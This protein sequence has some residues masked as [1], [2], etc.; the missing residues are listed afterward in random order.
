MLIAKQT[1]QKFSL[2]LACSLLFSIF[3][4]CKQDEDLSTAK[5]LPALHASDA[6]VSSLY[7]KEQ[8]KEL[9]VS[10]DELA[11]GRVHMQEFAN[12]IERYLAKKK[13]APEHVA[14]E[15][16]N[17]KRNEH[18]AL[19]ENK[20][21]VAASTYKFPLAVIYYDLLRKG[22]VKKTSSLQLDESEVMDPYGVGA[23]SVGSLINVVDLLN[24]MILYS[25]N[26][27]A[28]MLFEEL[29]G[30][31]RY[32][33]LVCENVNL[34]KDPKYLADGNHISTT[35]LSTFAK[36]VYENQENYEAL[37]CNMQKAEPVHYLNL[38]PSMHNVM[39]QKYGSYEAALNS[40]GLQL[41][42]DEQYS[43][44]VLTDLGQ[45]GEQVV[46]EISALAYAFY[47]PDKLK[48][49]NI[50]EQAQAFQYFT[51]A[52]Y[53]PNNG[54]SLSN[55]QLESA[56]DL[57]SQ[58]RRVMEDDP[59]IEHHSSN[60]PEYI[61]R[62]N[63]DTNTSS[64]SNSHFGLDAYPSSSSESSSNSGTSSSSETNSSS[65]TSSNSETN[66]SSGTTSTSSS[67][68]TEP[69]STTSTS[70]SKDSKPSKDAESSESNSDANS[71]SKLDTGSSNKT[72]DNSKSEDDTKTKQAANEN[73]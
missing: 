17:F 52:A 70:S 37:L 60:E 27:A 49:E 21:F 36:K 44:V 20:Y 42:G 19:N 35:I 23:N 40:V 16:Y 66:S 30:F 56:S 63:E 51:Q 7:T 33:E 54:N 45:A 6:D 8:S 58:N 62:Y 61:S 11:N 43:L 48:A 39:V 46:G 5:S 31:R 3:T 9:L 41:K 50:I 15:L 18:F 28:H 38:L 13:L 14:I 57:A 68:Q 29:G 64:N 25:D 34:P 26:T 53:A 4:G 12:L 59:S 73:N 24:P 47:Y 72:E 69:S 67:I 2:V 22:T 10:A 1:K 32:K 71:D 65:G 55:G